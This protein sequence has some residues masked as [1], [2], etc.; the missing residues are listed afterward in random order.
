MLLMA[1]TEGRGTLKMANW[2]L[3]LFGMSFLPPPGMFI[4]AKYLHTKSKQP[5]MRR[6][7]VNTSL[8]TTFPGASRAQIKGSN[9]GSLQS[10]RCVADSAYSNLLFRADLIDV[11]LTCSLQ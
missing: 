4:A 11:E 3:S 1:A 6:S 8:A 5:S 10:T 2:R 9:H 7:A